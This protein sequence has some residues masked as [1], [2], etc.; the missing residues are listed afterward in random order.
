M[1]YKCKST[2]ET[3]RNRTSNDLPITPPFKSLGS[4]R[5][6]LMIIL[7]SKVQI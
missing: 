4:E 6:F 3:G 7:F 1:Q 5:F 2:L